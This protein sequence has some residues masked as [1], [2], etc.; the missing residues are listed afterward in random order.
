MLFKVVITHTQETH[1]SQVKIVSS[2]TSSLSG[3]DWKIL[4]ESWKKH[5]L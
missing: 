2:T 4:Q 1:S 3:M 5:N